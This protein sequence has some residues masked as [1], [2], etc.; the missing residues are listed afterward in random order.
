MP[1]QPY[2]PLEIAGHAFERYHQLVPGQ[3]A[4][5]PA[6]P[7]H[8]HKVGDEAA[9]LVLAMGLH[10]QVRRGLAAPEG[11]G[12]DARGDHGRIVPGQSVSVREVSRSALKQ[13]HA[14]L[15]VPGYAG[16]YKCVAAFASSAWQAK[17]YEA[18]KPL[19]SSIPSCA[20][21]IHL[22][23]P[24]PRVVRMHTFPRLFTK[25]FRFTLHFP[26]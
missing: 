21:R 22:S 8:R 18:E 20:R 1:G 2:Q 19:R 26:S 15:V 23:S 12:L 14:D 7:C 11:R 25:L 5:W 3:P 10:E 17:R 4:S 13:M 6:P 16:S 24:A 9:H